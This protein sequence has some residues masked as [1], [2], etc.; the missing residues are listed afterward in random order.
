MSEKYIQIQ[1]NLPVLPVDHRYKAKH[2]DYVVSIWNE[3]QNAEAAML[4]LTAMANTGQTWVSLRQLFQ[5]FEQDPAARFA[6]ISG[7]EQMQEAFIWLYN[8]GF[9]DINESNQ[10]VVLLDP[11][12]ALINATIKFESLT[13]EKLVNSPTL[14]IRAASDMYETIVL[15]G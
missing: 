2:N 3:W 13:T 11:I 1:R 10:S 12:Y 14:E 6:R 5:I 7:K 8:Q 9:I 15:E 4:I